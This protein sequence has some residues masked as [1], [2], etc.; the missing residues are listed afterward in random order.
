M[1]VRKAFPQIYEYDH[2]K[3]AAISQSHVA[4][5]VKGRSGK[6]LKEIRFEEQIP[7]DVPAAGF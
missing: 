1:I 7:I 6:G 3:S 5:A 2:P 4:G